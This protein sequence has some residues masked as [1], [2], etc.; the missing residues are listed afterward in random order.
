MGIPTE[1]EKVE[2]ATDAGKMG[3]RTEN[4]VKHYSRNTIV[5]CF[6]F[7]PPGTDLCFEQKKSCLLNNMF[8]FTLLQAKRADV[9]D[10]LSAGL[11]SIKIFEPVQTV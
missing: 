10:K 4:W 1:N 8:Q 2:T 3:C 7:I 9:H 6:V 11:I 5:D